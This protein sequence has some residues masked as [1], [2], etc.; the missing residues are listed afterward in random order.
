MGLDENDD[1]VGE[2]GEL[3]AMNAESLRLVAA[4]LRQLLKIE[5][6]QTL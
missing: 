4:F 5:Q 1:G 6:R 2:V 3:A